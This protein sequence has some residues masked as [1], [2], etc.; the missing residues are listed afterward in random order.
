VRLLVTLMAT[1]THPEAAM[2]RPETD[3]A[4]FDARVRAVMPIGRQT[5][6]LRDWLRAKFRAIISELEALGFERWTLDGG[7]P[8]CGKPNR[9]LRAP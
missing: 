4:V 7:G 6:K 1:W 8:V 5:N 3:D 2:V 9:A